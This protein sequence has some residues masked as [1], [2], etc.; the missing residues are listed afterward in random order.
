M[1]FQ[2]QNDFI[3][4][5]VTECLNLCECMKISNNTSKLTQMNSFLKKEITKFYI[6]DRSLSLYDVDGL[7]HALSNVKLSN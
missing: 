6:S 1:K 3:Y 4:E 7:D 5:Y 2:N